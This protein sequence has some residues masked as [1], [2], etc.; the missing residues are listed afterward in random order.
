[1]KKKRKKEVIVE[2]ELKIQT[3]V[4][5]EQMRKKKLRDG[6][7]RKKLSPDYDADLQ[8]RLRSERSKAAV[9][10][11]KEDGIVIV[12]SEER[13]KK[14]SEIAKI[15]SAGDKNPMFGKR[16]INN[17]NYG[18]K[19]TPEQRIKYTKKYIENGNNGINN[20]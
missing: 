12:F 8:F 11:R 9:A 13:R 18:S 17:P 4:K 14:M 6:H 7:A 10:K 16:G 20:G 2:L 15:N 3:L 1:M 5:K 19:R